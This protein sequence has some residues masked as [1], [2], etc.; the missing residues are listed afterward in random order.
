[1]A[2]YGDFYRLR[3]LIGSAGFGLLCGPRVAHLEGRRRDVLRPEADASA[4]T[5]PCELTCG[6]ET[7]D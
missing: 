3:G 6:N 2:L 7:I 5:N 1:L 4:E